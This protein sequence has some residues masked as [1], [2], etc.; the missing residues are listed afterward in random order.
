MNRTLQ[1]LK[2]IVFNPIINK[3][4][5]NEGKKKSIAIVKKRTKSYSYR[6]SIIKKYSTNRTS[7]NFPN[8]HPPRHLLILIAATFVYKN[9][10][11]RSQKNKYCYHIFT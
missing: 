6:Y 2:N 1:Y 3:T 10:I 4:I 11:N 7:N 8:S 9:R 5:V